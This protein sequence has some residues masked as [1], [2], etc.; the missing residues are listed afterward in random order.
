MDPILDYYDKQ[1]FLQHA[2]FF[3][4]ALENPVNSNRKNLAIQENPMNSN[5]KTLAIQEDLSL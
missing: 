1:V 5:R 2:R 4:M 3:F